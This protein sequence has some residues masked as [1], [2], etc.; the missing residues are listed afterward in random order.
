MKCVFISC[1][2]SAGLCFGL[3]QAV[4]A[5]PFP[6]T[7]TIAGLEVHPAEAK[8]DKLMGNY[9]NGL[10][11]AFAEKDDKKTIAMVNKLNDEL[12]TEL[13]KIKPELERW[14][15]GMTEADKEAFK[16]RAESKPYL[17][18]IFEIMFN[19]EIGKRVENNP[20]L[21]AAMDAGNKRVE[22]LG[23]EDEGSNEGDYK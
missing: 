5:A 15:K 6:V 14:V 17:K 20:E 3:L 19:P 7:T 10:K 11:A 22:S 21:K 23:F 9:A 8:Y 18:T 13:E 4:A 2:L 1:L 12:Y 16:Q